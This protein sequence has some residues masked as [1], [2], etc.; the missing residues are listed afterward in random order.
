MKRENDIPKKRVKNY[1]IK[2]VYY[3]GWLTNPFGM[4]FAFQIIR[5]D[6]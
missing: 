4:V 6:L 5:S 1:L 2:S 3:L